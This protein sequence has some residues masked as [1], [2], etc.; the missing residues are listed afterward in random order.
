MKTRVL[1]PTDPGSIAAASNLLSQGELVAFPTETVY[2][3]GAN[4]LDP[5]A[6]ARIFEA[7]GRP[8]DNPLILH[9]ENLEQALPLWRINKR[10][11]QLA[12]KLA[13]NFWPGP[14]SLVL[15]ASSRVPAAVTA[16]LDS[17]AVRAPANPV[18]RELLKTCSF[19]LA[20][21][22]AN[23]SGRPSPTRAEHVAAT[24]QG[25][26]AVILDAGPTELGIESTV[27]DLRRA[28][29]RILRPGSLSRHDLAAVIGEVAEATGDR[30]PSPGL[31]HHHYRPRGVRLRLVST[32]AV[33]AAWSEPGGILCRQTTG[34]RLGARSGALWLLPDTASAYAA[35]LYHA[36]HAVEQSGVPSCLIEQIPAA[37]EWWAIRDRLLRATA[38]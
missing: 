27:I 24:L 1:D 32:A 20:A 31:R 14:L 4:G 35:G 37:P 21:P 10:Q 33:K 9:V 16:G 7:K 19:P 17:V 23:L 5:Q 28:R 36:L 15:P 8:G 12:S 3:L 22:S 34:S 38:D 6:V 25:R 26:I 2:G 13:C 18:A 11:L 29:P 30:E